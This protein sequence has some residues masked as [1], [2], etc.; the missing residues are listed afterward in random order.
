MVRVDLTLRGYQVGPRVAGLR[1]VGHLFIEYA[2]AGEDARIFRAGPKLGSDGLLVHASDT[3]MLIS[4][5]RPSQIATKSPIVVQRSEIELGYS[6]NEFLTEIDDLRRDINQ[7]ETFYGLFVDNSNS[8]ADL[9]W[10]LITKREL[11]LPD[12][13]GGYNFVGRMSK[14]IEQNIE[15]K[16]RCKRLTT[17]T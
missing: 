8:V 17:L 4:R 9:A 7:T 13:G 11:R 14:K 5:D 12:G 3:A 10:R 16:E 15:K 1:P 6:Y 2:K